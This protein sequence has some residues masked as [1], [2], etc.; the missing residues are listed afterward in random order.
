MARAVAGYS[1]SIVRCSGSRKSLLEPPAGRV[2]SASNGSVFVGALSSTGRTL[3][4]EGLGLNTG[5]RAA[6]TSVAAAVLAAHFHIVRPGV[7]LDERALRPAPC[8]E[9]LNAGAP[10]RSARRK[11]AKCSRR[12]GSWS[13]MIQQ[14]GG[15]LDERPQACFAALVV[16]THGTGADPKNFCGLVEGKLLIKRQMQ[17]GCLTFRQLCQQ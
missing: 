6:M 14:G 5:I 4:S 1:G 2:S 13:F 7:L 3:A 9:W 11:L 17:H 12:S 10:S 16:L 15:L 8:S